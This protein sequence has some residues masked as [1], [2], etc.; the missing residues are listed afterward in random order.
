MTAT[1]AVAAWLGLVVVPAIASAQ[2]IAS[3]AVFMPYKDARPTIE[4]LRKDLPDELLE[5]DLPAGSDKWP[6]WA[7]KADASIRARLAQ[8][9]EDSLVNLLLLGRSFTEQPR[10]TQKQIEE[11]RTNTKGSKSAAGHLP[12]SVEARLEDFLTA[13]G[14]PG[15]GERITFAREFLG[16]RLGSLLT[17]DAGRAKARDLLLRSIARV[18]EELEAY[19]R[20]IEEAKLLGNDTAVFVERSEIYR[21]RGLSSDTSLRPNFGIETALAELLEKGFLKPA[22]IRRVA[23]IGPGLDF[24]DKQ[25]GHDFYPQQTIQPFAIMDSL[26]R[27]GLAKADELTVVTLDLSP[28][29][30][31]HIRRAR[32]RGEAG[33]RYTMQLPLATNGAWTEGFEKY[34]KRF[35]D[36]IGA[37][38][39]P[40]A[41]PAG[42]TGLDLR[43]IAVQPEF[44]AKLEATDVNIVLQRLELADDEKFDLVI[45]T[46]IFVYYDGFQKSLALTNIARMLRVGGFLLSNQALLEIP[47]AKLN[48]TGYSKVRYSN[49]T[50]VDGDFIV[51][52]RRNP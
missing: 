24:A 3:G 25:S 10:T 37:E 20:I 7:R 31:A 2:P 35:G 14:R 18:L 4:T 9:D 50:S 45:G 36:Q 52:Y 47:S 27:L 43:A 19:D 46:N 29:V 5:H 23:V 33:K 12:A 42:V 48:W 44:A 28:K 8:G 16:A 22:S 13:L 34:W 11:I 1:V 51:W 41:V 39:K 32:A 6:Q 49:R 40:V 26:L 30:N 38:T 21:E 17:S 15:G